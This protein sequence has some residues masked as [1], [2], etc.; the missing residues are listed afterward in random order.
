MKGEILPPLAESVHVKPVG[1]RVALRLGVPLLLL[2]PLFLLLML[3]ILLIGT[4][5]F[6]FTLVRA[7]STR[8]AG[9]VGLRGKPVRAKQTNDRARVKIFYE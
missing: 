6:G 9:L 4:V 5:F 7:L 8:L 1:G 3:P 2:L